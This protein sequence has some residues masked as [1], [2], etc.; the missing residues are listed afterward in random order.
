MTTGGPT[1]AQD[2]VITKQVPSPPTPDQRK[3]TIF[4]LSLFNECLYRA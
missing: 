1:T 2:I 3:C 4:P